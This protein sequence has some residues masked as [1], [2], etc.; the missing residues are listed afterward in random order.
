M[1]KEAERGSGKSAG[2]GAW[3]EDTGGDVVKDANGTDVEH[4]AVDDEGGRN[5][6]GAADKASADDGNEWVGAVG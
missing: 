5:I 4:V 3:A 2:V 6:H 1:T